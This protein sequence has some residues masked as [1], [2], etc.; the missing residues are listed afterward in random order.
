MTDERLNRREFIRKSLTTGIGLGGGM[1]L[2]NLKTASAANPPANP[3]DLVA[4]KN[5]EPDVMFNKAIS[6]I[7]GMN[8]FVKKGQTVVVKPNI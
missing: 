3:P 1:I 6:M 7:G 4:V 8:R 5:H 2:G